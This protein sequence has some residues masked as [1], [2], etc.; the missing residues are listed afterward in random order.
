[1]VSA[2][3]ASLLLASSSG[4]V[5]LPGMCL[6]SVS[7]PL[8]AFVVGPGFLP[9]SDK[10]VRNIVSGAFVYLATLLSKAS[11]AQASAPIVTVDGRVVVSQALRPPKRLPDITLWLQ[12][13]S[14][15]TLVVSHFPARAVDLLRDLTHP[16]T[17]LRTCLV[18]LRRSLSSGGG[19]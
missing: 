1:M 9:I 7:D 6:P 2:S 14:I 12:A 5:T 3:S 13:F 11:E 18:Q 16:R 17:V 8:P 10:I 4:V 15:Y 19:C